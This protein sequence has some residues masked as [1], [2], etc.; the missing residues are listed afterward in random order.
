MYLHVKV[1]L[2][3]FNRILE[4]N[5]E[6]NSCVLHYVSRDLYLYIDVLFSVLKEPAFCRLIKHLQELLHVVVLT[7]LAYK[8]TDRITV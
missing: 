8:I 1:S 7:L 4:E 5:I 6:G 2:N 3:L